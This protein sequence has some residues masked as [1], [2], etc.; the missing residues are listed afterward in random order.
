MTAWGRPNDSEY[1]IKPTN[2]RHPTKALDDLQ[3]VKARSCKSDGMVTKA[4]FFARSKQSGRNLG[5]AQRS[6][7][8]LAESAAQFLPVPFSSEVLKDDGLVHHSIRQEMPQQAPLLLGTQLVP[9]LLQ[10]LQV[11]ATRHH[12]PCICGLRMAITK[13]ALCCC[14]LLYCH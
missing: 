12:T 3:C 9:G 7:E 14:C 10:L 1:F 5:T 11:L 4:L 8:T 2:L 6:E 13:V